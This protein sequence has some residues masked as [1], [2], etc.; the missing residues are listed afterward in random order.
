MLKN[1][2]VFDRLTLE[3]KQQLIVKFK[4]KGIELQIYETMP[5]TRIDWAIINFT[6]PNADRY[7]H[8]PS[9][10][11]CKIAATMDVVDRI[12]LV[13]AVQIEAKIICQRNNLLSL[14]PAIDSDGYLCDSVVKKLLWGGS[15]E[16]NKLNPNE[17]NLFN[18]IVQGKSNSQIAEELNLSV[19]T[20]KTYCSRICQKLAVDRQQLKS[21]LFIQ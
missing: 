5:S 2:L 18:S 17:I 16:L 9:L 8:L 14:L 15:I 19:S 3:K 1:L 6:I 7:L 11:S 13:K 20:V 21:T 12:F 10:K 4:Q